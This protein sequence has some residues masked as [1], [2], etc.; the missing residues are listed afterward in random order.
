MSHLAVDARFRFLTTDEI[1]EAARIILPETDFAG[2]KVYRL[3]QD[4]AH[5]GILTLKPQDIF[6]TRITGLVIVTDQ[7]VGVYQ[8][9]VGIGADSIA[10]T[11]Q[12][13][14]IVNKDST[15]YMTLTDIVLTNSSG[16][17]ANVQVLM[18]GM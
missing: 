7:P 16:L 1:R 14:A 8:A 18:V 4:L 13:V 2:Q 9:R 12:V 15:T 3:D 5:F 6:T 11:A 17:T 10:V